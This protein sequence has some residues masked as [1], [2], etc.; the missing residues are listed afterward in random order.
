MKNAEVRKILTEKIT[1][2][3]S[4]SKKVIYEF[5]SHYTM[6][7]NGNAFSIFFTDFDSLKMANKNHS[8]VISFL[9]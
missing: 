8:E 7:L 2:E 5:L 3:I 6:N 9:Q 1:K 4:K